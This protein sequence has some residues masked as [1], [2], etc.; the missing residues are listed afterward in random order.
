MFRWLKFNMSDVTELIEALIEFRNERE[1]N[2]FHN[3][4]DL[5]IALNIKAGELLEF[6]YGNLPKKQIKKKSRKNLQMYLPT[7]CFWLKI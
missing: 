2:Q 3:P 1:W 4:K 5:A 7:R 6:F